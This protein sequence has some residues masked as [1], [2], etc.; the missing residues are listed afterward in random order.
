MLIEEWLCAMMPSLYNVGR[1]YDEC[2]IMNDYFR[3][4]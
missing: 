3:D 1:R 2:S 4:G